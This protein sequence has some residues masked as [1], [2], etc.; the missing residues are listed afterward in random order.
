MYLTSPNITQTIAVVKSLPKKIRKSR[1]AAP[2]AVIIFIFFERNGGP[3]SRERTEKDG[4]RVRRLRDYRQYWHY[5]E[6]A[7]AFGVRKRCSISMANCYRQGYAGVNHAAWSSHDIA[8][9]HI[10]RNK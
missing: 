1:R 2:L 4:R 8:G 7:S 3:S 9:S 6:T 10:L 5:F